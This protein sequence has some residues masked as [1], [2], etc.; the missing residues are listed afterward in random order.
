MTDLPEA[1]ISYVANGDH[2]SRKVSRTVIH[3]PE[4]IALVQ[5]VRRRMRELNRKG[6]SVLYVDFVTDGTHRRRY[7][8][9]RV[10]RPRRGL[11][12]TD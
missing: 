1:T 12:E 6:A 10:T 4:R 8:D 3:A 2:A 11:T 9:G 7:V 5:E